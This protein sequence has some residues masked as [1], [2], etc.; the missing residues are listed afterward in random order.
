MAHQ[1]SVDVRNAQADAFETV[2]GTSAI[3][4]LR[5][6]APPAN[7][8]TADSGTVVATLNLPADYLSNAANGTKSKS[9]T[10]E[11]PAADAAGTI[12]HFRIYK[13][14][15]VTCTMQ[16]TVTQTGSGGDVT[17]D[18]PVAQTGQYIIINTF[19]FTRGNA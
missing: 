7:C 1:Y 16:G 4:K 18:N 6:G 3:L 12:G 5:T 8:A 10:W 19:S 2:T 15:G 13:S 9:G 11:D 17:V 14:D